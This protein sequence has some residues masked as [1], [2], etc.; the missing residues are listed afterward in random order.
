MSDGA[1]Q[2]AT[3]SAASDAGCGVVPRAQLH[4]QTQTRE[5]PS[6]YTCCTFQ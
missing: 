3:A 4:Q 5:I 2:G 1:T 6:L